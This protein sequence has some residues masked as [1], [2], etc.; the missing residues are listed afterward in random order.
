MKKKVKD[1][2]EGKIKL[3]EKWYM[4]IDPLNYILYKLKKTTEEDG[5]I[6]ETMVLEGYYGRL[7]HLIAAI[8]T[9]HIDD[10]MAKAL[11]GNLDTIEILAKEIKDN[12]IKNV[13]DLKGM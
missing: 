3:T 2:F 7:E 12:V 1:I 11:K 9:K 10:N 4:S 8:L 6:K 5:Q 13:G